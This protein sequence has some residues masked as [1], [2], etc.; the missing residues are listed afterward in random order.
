M[1]VIS[2]ASRDTFAVMMKGKV[3]NFDQSADRGCCTMGDHRQR[4]F[5]RQA[6]VTERP[7]ALPPVTRGE[8][9]MGSLLAQCPNTSALINTGVETDAS[10]LA[11]AWRSALRVNCPHCNEVHEIRVN[12]AYLQDVMSVERRYV[13]PEL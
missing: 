3:C 10:S 9:I 8:A 7:V 2:R 4:P 5:L 1:S 13:R 12:E 6:P 11:A